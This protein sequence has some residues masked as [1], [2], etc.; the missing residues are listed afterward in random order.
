MKVVGTELI[1][2]ETKKTFLGEINEVGKGCEWEIN[3][4]EE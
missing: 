4:N 1:K 3:K 2:G